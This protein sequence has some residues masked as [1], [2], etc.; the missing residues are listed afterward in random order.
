MTDTVFR[1]GEALALEKSES[2]SALLQRWNYDGRI[3]VALNGVV[4]PRSQ[5]ADT[6][7]RPGDEI[8]IVAPMKGG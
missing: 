7:V 2:L 5:L 3:A 8:E 1:N 4:V 6:L